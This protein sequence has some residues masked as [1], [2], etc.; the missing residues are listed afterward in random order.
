MRS[1]DDVIWGLGL[2]CNG[3]VKVCLQL[4]DVKNNFSPLN[5]IIEAIRVALEVAP[6]ELS[7]D[8]ADRGIVMTGGGSLLSNLDKIISDATQLPI[9][10][11]DT[12]LLCVAK[13][14]GRVLDDMSKFKHVL[15]K[16]N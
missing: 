2:G 13:G 6:P 5:Q 16:Q 11:A 7:S 9:I 4:L 1:P 12:P 10:L 8:I 14:C 3:A 15:F